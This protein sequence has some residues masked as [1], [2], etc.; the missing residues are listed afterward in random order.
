MVQVVPDAPRMPST[1][2][3]VEVPVPVLVMVSGVSTVRRTTGPTVLLL[4]VLAMAPPRPSLIRKCAALLAV[5]RIRALRLARD[6]HKGLG[7]MLAC[8]RPVGDDPGAP[9]QIYGEHDREIGADVVWP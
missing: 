7:G 2:E 8:Q 6:Q 3:P 1:P 4:I 5:R 9:E